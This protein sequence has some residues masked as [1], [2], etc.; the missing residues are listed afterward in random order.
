M[1]KSAIF[2]L[3]AMLSPAARATSPAV[4]I[5]LEYYHG[6]Q[7][8]VR[9]TVHG[10]A[11]RFLFDTGEGVTMISPQLAAAIGCTPWG[12]VTGFRMLGERLD[13]KRCDGL[14]ISLQGQSFTAP[15]AIVFD[16]AA[17]SGKDDPPVDGAI[18]LDIFAGQAVTLDWSARRLIVET[19]ASMAARIAHAQPVPIR[20]VRDAEGLALTVDI[21]I[22]TPRGLAWMELDSGNGGPTIFTSQA[23]APLLGLDPVKKEPQP[24][25]VSLAPGVH[26]AEP[27]RV[28]PNMIMDGNIGAQ[29]LSKWEVT[30]DLKSNRA[31]LVPAGESPPGHPD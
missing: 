30:F 25:H 16:L 18:G 15:T 12:N 8:A 6:R 26:L 17:I 7:L 20:L 29:F 13:M 24:V 10:K 9:A 27:A 4:I 5:P 21:A 11:A 1:K 28:F 19:A 2:L 22:P 14:N 31:W 3:F 23:I